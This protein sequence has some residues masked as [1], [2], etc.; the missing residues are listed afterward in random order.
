VL[1]I[2]YFLIYIYPSQL[3]MRNFHLRR[4]TKWCPTINLD[5]L[6]TLVSEQT[7]LKY[8]DNENKA[9]VIDLV[10]A[11]SQNSFFIFV[12]TLFLSIFNNFFLS[13]MM[14]CNGRSEKYCTILTILWTCCFL[15]IS[16]QNILEIYIRYL[17]I[18]YYY[19]EYIILI[20]LGI[21]QTSWKGKIA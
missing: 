12:C 14:I 2:F 7:R 6:W 18:L 1:S 15:K 13:L 9:P 19:M 8:K 16:S 20:F 5:K 3:G 17:K 11:V 21:L 4:N 10:K